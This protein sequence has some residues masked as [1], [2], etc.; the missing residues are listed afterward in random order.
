MPELCPSQCKANAFPFR[1]LSLSRFSLSAWF[2][3]ASQG[4]FLS[5]RTS[6]GS[7]MSVIQLFLCTIPGLKW[8]APSCVSLG[9]CAYLF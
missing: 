2:K 3:A 7:A 6:H 1:P 8:E 4:Q 5:G 9:G